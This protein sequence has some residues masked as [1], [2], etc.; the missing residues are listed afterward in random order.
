M[1][2][3]KSVMRMDSDQGTDSEVLSRAFDCLNLDSIA[4]GLCFFNRV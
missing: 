3:S 1:S 2:M 4:S